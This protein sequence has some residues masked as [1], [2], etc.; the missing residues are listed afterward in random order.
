[1]GQGWLRQLAGHAVTRQFL[2][3]AAVGAVATSAHFVVLIALTEL[4]GVHPV[5]ATTCGFAAG[6]IVSYTLN[7]RYT[8]EV[9]PDF[10]RGFAK[11]AVLIAIGAVLNAAIV[12][13]LMHLGLYYLIAQ[14]IATSLVLIW[15]FIGARFLVFR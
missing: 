4:A 8:F 9:R 11:F 2:R 15:N 1:M 14:V 5:A 12:A 3:F 10:A 13:G 6:A 7:R